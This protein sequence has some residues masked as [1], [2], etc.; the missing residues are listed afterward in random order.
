MVPQQMMRQL[1]HD[2]YQ[3]YNCT[4]QDSVKCTSK[5]PG[6]NQTGGHKPQRKSW[7]YRQRLGCLAGVVRPIFDKSPNLTGRYLEM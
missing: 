4:A 6:C 2:L 1:H 3:G 5:D 7:G